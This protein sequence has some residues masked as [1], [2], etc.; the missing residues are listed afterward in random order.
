MREEAHNISFKFLI[1]IDVVE[2]VAWLK[3]G[4]EI[5]MMTDCILYTQELSPMQ[6]N[7]SYGTKYLKQ[8]IRTLIMAIHNNIS[9]TKS[10]NLPVILTESCLVF[11]II[12]DSIAD[13]AIVTVMTIMLYFIS[14]SWLV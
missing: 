4:E 2:G 11:T 1:L 7:I 3:L 13:V 14:L 12:T 10:N 9:F 5:E 8:T 6:G